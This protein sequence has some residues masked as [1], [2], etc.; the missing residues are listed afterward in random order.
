MRLSCDVCAT[1]ARP[2]G[3]GDA[4]LHYDVKHIIVIVIDIVIVLGA[5]TLT[6]LI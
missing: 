2:R 3:H 6:K 4:S 5:R 1:S